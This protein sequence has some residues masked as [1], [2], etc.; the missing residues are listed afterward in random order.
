MWIK[1]DGRGA[2]VNT[3]ALDWIDYDE[4]YDV[5]KGYN[6]DESWIISKGN[7]VNLVFANLR[8]GKPTMEVE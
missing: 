7:T 4:R 8:M 6:G 3:D 1:T 5:T 2:L